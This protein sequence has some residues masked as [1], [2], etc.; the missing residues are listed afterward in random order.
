MTP[1]ALR[2]AALLLLQI[3]DILVRNRNKRIWIQ[4]RILLFLSVTFKTATKI[5]FLRRFSAYYFWQ[6]YLHHFSKIKSHKEV[7]KQ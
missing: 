1:L 6:V 5:Y 7:T 2:Q 4:L 3:L